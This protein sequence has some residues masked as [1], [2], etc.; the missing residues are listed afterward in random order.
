MIQH[1]AFIMDGNRRW[2]KKQGL[3]PFFGHNK[4]AEAI[5]HVVNFCLK[6]DIKYV[7]LYTFSLENLKRPA[8]E[9]SYLFD[10]LINEAHKK[11]DQFIEQ[12][13]RV[14]FIGDRQLFP[15]NA[16]ITIAMVE[17]KTAECNALNLNILFCYGARQ[18]IVGGIKKLF[19][20]IKAGLVALEDLSEDLFKQYLW[21]AEIPEPELIIRTGGFKRLSNFLLYQAA[22]SELHFIDCL[23]PEITQEHMQIAVDSYIQTQRNFGG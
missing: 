20:N 3:L 5:K 11:L 22:Y 14:R 8:L 9:V 21:T 7:S 17:E 12:G 6:S 10:L 4:G 2:A 23:W 13:V 15:N 1:L 19:T 18:E 16:A